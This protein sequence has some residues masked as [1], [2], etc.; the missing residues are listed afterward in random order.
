MIII[1][2]VSH[3]VKHLIKG[4]FKPYLNILFIRILVNTMLALWQLIS[5]ILKNKRELTLNTVLISEQLW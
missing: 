3:K 4:F 5:F 2:D 1:N